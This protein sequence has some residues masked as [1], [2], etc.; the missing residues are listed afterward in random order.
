MKILSKVQWRPRESQ[1]PSKLQLRT[2][3]SKL[4]LKIPMIKMW[5][6]MKLQKQLTLQSWYPK[7]N[8]L[9]RKDFTLK[10]NKI[11]PN[12][13]PK[14]QS[15]L[16]FSS[17][18]LVSGPWTN[19][20]KSNFRHFAEIPGFKKFVSLLQ[21]SPKWRKLFLGLSIRSLESIFWQIWTQNQKNW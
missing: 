10:F 11:R 3:S 17:R 12:K 2:Q 21:I 18:E 4:N 20:T 6:N 19:S 5:Y 13:I 15:S 1:R 8:L 16:T 14:K 9:A 7:K